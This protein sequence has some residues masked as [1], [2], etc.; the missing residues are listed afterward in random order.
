MEDKIESCYLITNKLHFSVKT[1]CDQTILPR[2]RTFVY[3]ARRQR[4]DVLSNISRQRHVLDSLKSDKI[5]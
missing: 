2:S 3:S 1:C 5:K 4:S